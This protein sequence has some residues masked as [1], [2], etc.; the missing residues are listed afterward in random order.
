MFEELD[1]MDR[2]NIV[3]HDLLFYGEVIAFDTTVD[4]WAA[5]IRKVMRDS[6]FFEIFFELPKKLRPVICLDGFHGEGVDMLACHIPIAK[7]R[8]GRHAGVGISRLRLSVRDVDI[9]VRADALL[10]RKPQF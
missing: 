9:L 6:S 3:L 2:L 8:S 10:D 5:R 4:L 7:K 1:I